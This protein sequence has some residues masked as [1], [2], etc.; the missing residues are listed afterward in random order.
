MAKLGY[1]ANVIKNV[2]CIVNVMSCAKYREFLQD[3]VVDVLQNVIKLHRNGQNQKHYYRDS[4]NTYLLVHKDVKI[5]I[6]EWISK[7][8]YPHKQAT[9]FG[10]YFF[11]FYVPN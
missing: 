6:D 4:I 3:C 7:T 9:H 5:S 8:T 11:Q 10:V 1:I 2:T